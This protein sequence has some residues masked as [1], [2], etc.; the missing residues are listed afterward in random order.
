MNTR[1]TDFSS[2]LENRNKCLICTNNLNVLFSINMPVFMGVNIDN[3]EEI[4]QPMTFCECSECGEVQIKELLNLELLYHDNHNIGIVGKTWEKH[5]DKLANFL[6]DEIKGKVILEISDPSAKIAKRCNGYEKW[7]IIEP[8]PEAIEIDKVIFINKFFDDTFNDIEKVDVIIHSHLLEHIHNPFEF[9]NKCWD[10]LA[11][12]GLMFISVPNMEYL[13]DNFYAPNNILHFE[14]TYFLSSTILNYL[15]TRT[16]F[17]ILT[18][19]S[20]EN[21]SMFYKLK[22][23]PIK[24]ISTISTKQGDKFIKSFIKHSGEIQ[25]LNE[26]INFHRNNGFKVFLFGAHVTSQYYIN[27]GL[28][29]KIDAILDN[30][31]TKQGYKLYGSDLIVKAPNVVSDEKC[32]V[33]CSH[34]GVYEKEISEQ[35]LKLNENVILL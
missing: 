14:H 34:S 26:K 30:S 29:A 18:I 12:D 5:Y 19:K 22:K 13:I 9:L 11:D 35:L 17:E 32:V 21:H 3:R 16:G 8:N 2:T 25:L 1:K 20:Y 33:I 15:A 28:E 31:I 10:L 6:N 7:V 4:I 24:E 27:N 23:K